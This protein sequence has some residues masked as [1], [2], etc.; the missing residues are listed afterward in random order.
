MTKVHEGEYTDYIMTL[1]RREECKSAVCS[2]K[3]NCN[4]SWERSVYWNLMERLFRDRTLGKW[5]IK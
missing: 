2:G 4:D 3:W 1:V 5:I